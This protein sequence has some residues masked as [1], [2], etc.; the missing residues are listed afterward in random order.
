M[1][2]SR[3]DAWVQRGVVAAL[4]ALA[5]TLLGVG[6]AFYAVPT[7]NAQGTAGVSVGR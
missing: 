6:V 7:A 5:V 1:P 2:N 3:I 4:V